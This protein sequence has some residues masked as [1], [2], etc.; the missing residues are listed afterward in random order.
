MREKKM[1]SDWK[2]GKRK[3]EKIKWEERKVMTLVSI[4]EEK[5]SEIKKGLSFYQPPLVI[6]YKE[7]ILHTNDLGRYFPSSIIS[8]VQ[9]LRSYKLI[10]EEYLCSII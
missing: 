4:R 3:V 10:Y 7:S 9:S 2:Q 5:Y 6:L 8:F 1:D